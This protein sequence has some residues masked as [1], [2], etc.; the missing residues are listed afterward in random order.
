ML[1]SM[2]NLLQRV[3]RGRFN[4][5]AGLVSLMGASALFSLSGCAHLLMRLDGFESAARVL[6]AQMARTRA[7]LAP[8]LPP[9]LSALDRLEAEAQAGV[10]AALTPSDLA[11]LLNAGETLGYGE[12]CDMLAEAVRVT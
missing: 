11:T 10:E 12:V 5:V 9:G 4:R 6:G 1:R 7:G 3:N 8:S 2:K